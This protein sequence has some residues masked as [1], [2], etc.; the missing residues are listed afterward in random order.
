MKEADDKKL[1]D[2]SMEIENLK[3]KLADAVSRGDTEEV[4]KKQWKTE[5]EKLDALV[6]EKNTEIEE[7]KKRLAT[8]EKELR[9]SFSVQ[10][11]TA[12]ARTAPCAYAAD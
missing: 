12:I 3:K 7:L 4:E 6:C 5:K 9:C 10:S 11:V 8:L 1:A 2:F